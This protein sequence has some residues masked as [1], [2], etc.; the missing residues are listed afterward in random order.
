M[1]RLDLPPPRAELAGS[2]PDHVKCGGK[3]GHVSRP[4][5]YDNVRVRQPKHKA[6]FTHQKCLGVPDPLD[7]SERNQER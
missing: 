3:L 1:P 6:H 7:G 2:L 5:F 4:G